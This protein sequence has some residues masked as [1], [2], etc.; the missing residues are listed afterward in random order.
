MIYNEADNPIAKMSE[1]SSWRVVLRELVDH[2]LPKKLEINV[3]ETTVGEIRQKVTMLGCEASID[4]G[5][6]IGNLMDCRLGVASAIL[7][8]MHQGTEEL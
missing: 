3:G 7:A 6:D 4:F 8:A 1:K 5:T 2:A